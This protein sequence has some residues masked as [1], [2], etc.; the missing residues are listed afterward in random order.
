MEPPGLWDRWDG[1][2]MTEQEGGWESDLRGD[3]WQRTRG[4]LATLLHQH[5]LLMF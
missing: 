4:Q 2:W 3:A 5:S 1:G